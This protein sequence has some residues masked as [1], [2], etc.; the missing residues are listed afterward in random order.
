MRADDE[1]LVKYRRD[2]ERITSAFDNDYVSI[3]GDSLDMMS[4]ASELDAVMYQRQLV[5]EG[6]GD[7]VRLT[8]KQRDAIVDFGLQEEYPAYMWAKDSQSHS[9]YRPRTHL[10][11]GTE[12]TA[13]ELFGNPMNDENAMLEE[14]KKSDVF[15]APN[16]TGD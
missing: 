12:G 3:G 13:A 8:T 10:P 9:L 11:E 5:S 4:L 2:R 6:R 7:E 15:G 14:E 16:T 1:Y